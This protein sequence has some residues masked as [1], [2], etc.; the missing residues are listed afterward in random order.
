M[1]YVEEERKVRLDS[2]QA[3]P[4]QNKESLLVRQQDG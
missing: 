4:N 2:V 1:K 3:C